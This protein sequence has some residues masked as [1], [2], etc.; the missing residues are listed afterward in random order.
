MSARVRVQ[1]STQDADQLVKSLMYLSVAVLQLLL[2]CAFGEALRAA[3]AALGD[4]A[5]ASG[6]EL[7]A[8]PPRTRALALLLLRAQRPLVLRAGGLY[9]VTLNSFASVLNTSYS[10]F[11]LLR[12]INE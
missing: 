10:Y 2:V 3:G 6:W 1:S 7:R 5:Y 8:Q 12:T 4:A 9:P 11:A